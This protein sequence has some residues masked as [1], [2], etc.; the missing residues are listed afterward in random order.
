MSAEARSAPSAR[1]A[2]GAMLAI[3]LSQR[4]GS[5]ALQPGRGAPVVSADVP[6]SDDA[7]R[8]SPTCTPFRA[9][10]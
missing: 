6:P 9:S 5:V 8:T 1:T 10:T 2:A 4:S 7:T 3:E